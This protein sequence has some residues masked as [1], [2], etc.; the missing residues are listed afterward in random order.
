[1]RLYGRAVSGQ[2]I[3]VEPGSS[4]EEILD[5]IVVNVHKIGALGYHRGIAHEGKVLG[6]AMYIVKGGVLYVNDMSSGFGGVNKAC[7]ER[8][9]E[10]R[11]LVLV[12]GLYVEEGSPNDYIIGREARALEI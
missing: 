9:I 4:K 8:C 1:M 12:T 7:L 10:G 6:G 2:E 3:G 11:N 5:A